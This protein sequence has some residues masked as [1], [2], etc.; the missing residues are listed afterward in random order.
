MKGE[1]PETKH[2]AEGTSKSYREE[3]QPARHATGDQVL[4]LSF[5]SL[6]ITYCSPWF[7]QLSQGVQFLA[8]TIS[9][10]IF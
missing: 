7:K 1:G 9:L 2:T 8:V 6:E 4:Q 5:L 10:C 3:D